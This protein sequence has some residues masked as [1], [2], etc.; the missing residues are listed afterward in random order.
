MGTLDVTSVPFFVNGQGKRMK[1]VI[2]D[3]FAVMAVVGLSLFVSFDGPTW[4]APPRSPHDRHAFF[5]N[6]AVENEYFHSR[7][8][9]VAPS[10]LKF[11]NGRVPVDVDI[12]SSPPNSL[13]IS[14]KSVQGGEWRITI[15]APQRTQRTAQ[16]VGDTLAI[17][18]YALEGLKQS[19]SPLIFLQDITNKGV[20]SIPLLK[21]SSDLPPKKWVEIRAN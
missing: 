14:W 4:A 10:E 18:C 12:F 11:F 3:A 19:E 20:P 2:N 7:A 5:D 6:A 15:K 1:L 9:A 8:S 16:F 21:T 17:K 13:R